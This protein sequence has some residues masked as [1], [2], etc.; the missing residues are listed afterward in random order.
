[1]KSVCEGRCII[2]FA[3]FLMLLKE[4]HEA[5]LLIC[6]ADVLFPDDAPSWSKFS[7]VPCG[8]QCRPSLGITLTLMNV[9]GI[10]VR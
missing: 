4:L 8:M 7:S 10:S 2:V 6:L 3:S 9:S 1:M 5:A